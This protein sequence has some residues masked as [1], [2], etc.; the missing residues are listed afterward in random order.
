MKKTFTIKDAFIEDKQYLDEICKLHICS[1]AEAFAKIVA[2]AK[3]AENSKE[4]TEELNN[5]KDGLQ[6]TKDQ[7][8]I[9]SDSITERDKQIEELKNKAP[10]TVEITKEVIK[11]VEKPIELTGTQF[12]CELEEETAVFARKVRK[13]ALTDGHVNST[14]PHLYANQLINTAL[15]NFLDRKYDHLKR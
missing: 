13:F 2:A 14:D 4:T 3:T 11:E 6:W 7:L 12:I 1:Q 8:K 9:A 10:E 15:K 5:L